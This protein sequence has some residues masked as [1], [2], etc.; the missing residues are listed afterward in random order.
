MRDEFE[1]FVREH[2]NMV[3]STAMR[4]TNKSAEA[5]DISQQV[6]LQ[7]YRQFSKLKTHSNPGGWLR[8]AARNLSINYIKR[9]FKKWMFFDTVSD[10]PCEVETAFQDFNDESVFYNDTEKVKKVLDTLPFK[11]RVPLVLFYYETLTYL[12]IAEKL[13]CSVAKIKTD[14]FRAKKLFIKQMGALRSD[15][16]QK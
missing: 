14:I 9:Y 15:H 2:Q 7:A 10:I 12:E 13:N 4:I 16:D 1:N 11:S 3:F 6:F 5:E 8:L